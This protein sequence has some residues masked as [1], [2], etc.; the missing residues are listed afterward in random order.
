MNEEHMLKFLRCFK[1]L[2]KRQC[3]QV[4][5]ASFLS[6]GFTTMAV[7]NP[8]ETGKT[9]L[10]ALLYIEDCRIYYEQR[11]LIFGVSAKLEHPLWMLP[12]PLMLCLMIRSP[13]IFRRDVN[14]RRKKIWAAS[15][16]HERLSKSHLIPQK[17]FWGAK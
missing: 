12:E 4:R 15:S 1:T 16:S 6:S 17:Y 13:P 10:C 8:K 7:I 14:C 9:H 5:F 2:W 11:I 3:T